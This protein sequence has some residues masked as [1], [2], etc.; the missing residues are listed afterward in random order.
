MSDLIDLPGSDSLEFRLQYHGPAVDAGRMSARE[1]GP[2]ILGLGLALERA[3]ELLYGADRKLDVEVH[4][5]FTRGS[6]I[7]DFDLIQNAVDLLGSEAAKTVLQLLFGSAATGLGLFGIY[8]KLRRGEPLEDESAGEVAE[9][10]PTTAVQSG[11]QTGGGN[12]TFNINANNLSMTVANDATIQQGLADVLAPVQNNPGI[13]AVS[14]HVEQTQLQRVNREDV[15]LLAP[16]ME[17]IEDVVTTDVLPSVT[18]GL[19]VVP[20]YG[21]SK[22]RFVYNNTVFPAPILDE[23]W[24]QSAGSIRFGR[25]DMLQ[26]EAEVQT[27]RRG[28]TA[29]QRWKILKVHKYLPNA[30]QFDMLEPPSDIPDED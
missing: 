18:V 20:F 10:K 19:A 8:R 25:G 17:S 24:M 1:A 28:H 21:R 15:A 14:F 12:Y 7:I 2:A 27:I 13:E 16:P 11:D 26:V 5:D 3:S 9:S 30:A 4:A 6:F 23:E 29:E 22:W